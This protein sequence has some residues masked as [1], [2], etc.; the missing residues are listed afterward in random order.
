M[1]EFVYCFSLQHVWAAGEADRDMIDVRSEFSA[2]GRC[3]ASM[4]HVEL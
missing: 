4:C 2:C 1:K 3:L